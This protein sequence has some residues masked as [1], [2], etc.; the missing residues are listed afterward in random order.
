M[1]AKQLCHKILSKTSIHKK[2]VDVI[3]Q[4]IDTVIKAKTLSVTKIGR[5]ME[6]R[7]QTRSNIRKVDRVYSNKHLVLERERIYGAISDMLIKSERPFLLIDGSKLQ[8]SP[9]YIMRASLVS[10]GRA[11]TLYEYLYE[12]KVQKDRKLYKSFLNGLNRV[13]G[14][15]VT[16]ILITDAE[17]RGPWFNL[18]RAKGW[19]FIG[20]LRGQANIAIGEEEEPDDWHDYWPQATSKPKKLGQ[21]YYNKQDEIEGFF[22]LYKGKNKG[23]HAHTRTGR[24]SQ[25]IK[26]KRHKASSNE[27]WLI[28]SSLDTCAKYIIKAYQCRMTIEE[29]FRDT[30]SGR[31]GLGLKMTFS[32]QKSRYRVMLLIAALASM[33][34]YLVGTVGEK[35]NIHRKFQANST[36]MRRVLSRFYL[37]CEMLYKCINIKVN[38]WDDAIE[39]LQQEIY[40]C[41]TG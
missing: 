22:Y 34:A 1:R 27:P 4:V 15:E 26:S 31:Y 8:N 24:R 3:G 9:W 32:K 33:I 35:K 11:L 20:R 6:N 37:G 36:K 16:P 25:T 21:G 39:Q 28:I 12:E 38:E 19:D 17:F 30:K 14:N 13:L 7:C 10:Q 40:L 5:K 41:F 29:N 18:V 23:R 2:R